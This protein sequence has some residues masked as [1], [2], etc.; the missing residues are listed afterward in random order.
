MI[1]TALKKF[2]R[3]LFFYEIVSGSYGN[4]SSNPSSF[5]HIKYDC[6]TNRLHFPYMCTISNRSQMMSA[7]RVKNKKY[8][9]R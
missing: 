6:L 1:Y 9:M 3:A 5:I 8:D 2:D 4:G 7:K